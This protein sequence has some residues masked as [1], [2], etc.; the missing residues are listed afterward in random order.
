M[1]TRIEVTERPPAATPDYSD[2]FAVARTSSDSRS[3]E[4]WARAALEQ[5]PPVLRRGLPL[6][7]ESGLGLR[8]GPAIARPVWTLGSPVHRLT[9]PYLL[10]RAAAE[11]G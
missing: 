1:S 10:N 2:A 7:W 3:A 11:R 8:L 4:A 9:V 6:A 5:T